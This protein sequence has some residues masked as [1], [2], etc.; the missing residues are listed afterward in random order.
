MSSYMLSTNTH[1][2]LFLRRFQADRCEVLQDFWCLSSRCTWFRD[3]PG[4]QDVLRDPVSCIPIRVHGD[5]VPVSERV[6]KLN[7][8]NFCSAIVRGG[9]SQ[10]TRHPMVAFKCNKYMDLDDL[11]HVLAW[12]FQVLLA[13]KMPSHDQDGKALTGHRASLKGQDVAGGLKFML[14]QFLSDLAY[15]KDDL[16]LECNWQTEHLCYECHGHALPGPCCAYNFDINAQWT[17]T[18]KDQSQFEEDSTATTLRLWPG[19]HLGI[20]CIDLMHVLCLGILHHTLGS[21]LWELLLEDVWPVPDH[22]GG[23]WQFLRQKQLHLAYAD[24]LKWAKTTKLQHSEKS[25]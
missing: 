23:P 6:V 17:Q 8:I 20:I 13:G 18:M 16:Q 15:S 11:F 24:F 10:A 2:P 21:A 3:H 12:S 1:R 14:A 7:V 5:D 25:K 9:S 22:E 4:R 19:F